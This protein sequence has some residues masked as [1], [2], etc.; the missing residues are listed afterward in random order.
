MS[1]RELIQ[2]KELEI[3][4]TFSLVPEKVVLTEASRNNATGAVRYHSSIECNSL[5]ADSNPES[6][7]R[8]PFKGRLLPCR[9][10][11]PGALGQTDVDEMAAM[12]VALNVA[13]NNRPHVILSSSGFKAFKNG[14]PF[15][16]HFVNSCFGLRKARRDR[17]RT[18]RRNTVTPFGRQCIQCI[19]AH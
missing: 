9:I 14:E 15:V 12:F 13:D 8:G 7:N 3:A 10:C 1:S 18:I 17:L 4:A 2:R 19:A 16:Y 6:V 5:G 11:Y